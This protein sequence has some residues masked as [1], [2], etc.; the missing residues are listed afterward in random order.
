MEITIVTEEN[1]PFFKPLV[2]DGVWKG[3]DLM[4]GAI[5]EK[6]ACGVLAAKEEGTIFTIQ[7]LFVAEGFRRRGIGR[8]LLES[9]HEL[10]RQTRADLA[11]FQYLKKPELE[12]LYEFLKENDFEE[13]EDGTP[14]YRVA[15]KDLPEKYFGKA[16]AGNGRL[17]ALK[18]VSSRQWKQFMEMAGKTRKP[19]DGEIRLRAMGE[20]DQAAS[21]LKF[22]GDGCDGCILMY[23]VDGDYHLEYFCVL[24]KA[25]PADILSMFQASYRELKKRAGNPS[26]Y[27]NALT[28]ATEKMVNQVTGEKAV[29]AGMA[30][31]QYFVY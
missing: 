21:F 10:G 18:D 22:S 3:A 20:Y 5:E 26:I 17:I 30:V 14:V 4:L 29:L 7:Y 27:I 1:L 31:N 16:M 2:P 24:G 11:S 13:D 8:T 12:E 25:V 9:L 19:E 23:P 15:L 28:K 6:T